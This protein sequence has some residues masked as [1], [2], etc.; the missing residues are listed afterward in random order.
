[1]FQFYIQF[2]CC[3]CFWTLTLIVSVVFPRQ[4]A[5]FRATMHWVFSDVVAQLCLIMESKF[6][7]ECG[8]YW[9]CEF[10][11]I[12]MIVWSSNFN[13]GPHFNI[14]NFTS[15]FISCYQNLF[16]ILSSTILTQG[17]WNGLN[18]YLVYFCLF[19]YFIF[20]S[21]FLYT[22]YILFVKYRVNC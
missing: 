12:F 5:R 1:M 11:W 4:C 2:S 6:D 15:E 18:L 16:W 8:L 7:L 17:C 3:F 22:S 9:K 21:P 19:F 10:S 13:L 20:C 14:R